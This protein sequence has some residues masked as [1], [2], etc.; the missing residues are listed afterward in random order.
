[1][2]PT[3]T[4]SIEPGGREPAPGEL[5]VVQQFINSLDIEA[6]VD[7]LDSPAA[8]SGWLSDHGLARPGMRL[9]TGDLERARGFRELLRHL[10]LA[11]NGVALPPEVPDALNRALASLPLAGRFE[12][13]QARLVAVGSGLDGALGQ[14]AAIVISESLTGRWRRLKGCARDVCHWA[15]YDHSRSGTG[16]WCAMSICGSRTKA[17]TYY[18]RQRQSSPKSS[19]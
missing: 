10:A 15:F 7:D 11:N 16:T 3:A 19:A 13:G 4:E 6:G 14:L 9:T 18:R 5:R 2:R 12:D 17:I 1:V 8:L